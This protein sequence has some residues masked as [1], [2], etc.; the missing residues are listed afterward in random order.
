MGHSVPNASTHDTLA[1]DFNPGP[2]VGSA[3]DQP[4]SW[5]TNKPADPFQP[6]GFKPGTSFQAEEFTPGYK[7]PVPP[8]SPLV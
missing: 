6:G 8:G 2:G 5:E 4:A 1:S 7:D 3:G